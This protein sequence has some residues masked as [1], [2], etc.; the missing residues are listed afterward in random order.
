MIRNKKRIR[1]WGYKVPESTHRPSRWWF[2][3]WPEVETK[4][5]EGV[6][7]SST[8]ITKDK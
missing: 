5:G 7:A 6:E 1:I 4:G 3:I 8:L 2:E